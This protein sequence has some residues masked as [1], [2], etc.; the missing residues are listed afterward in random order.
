[1]I[2]AHGHDMHRLALDG[3]PPSSRCRQQPRSISQERSSKTRL[4]QWQMAP[5]HAPPV[6]HS[7]ATRARHVHAD[8]RTGAEPSTTPSAPPSGSTT[9]LRLR[10]AA[11]STRHA[12]PASR[13]ASCA[14]HLTLLKRHAGAAEETT[15]RAQGKVACTHVSIAARRE[16]GAGAGT[17]GTALGEREAAREDV[18]RSEGQRTRGRRRKERACVRE[19][20]VRGW[21]RVEKRHGARRRRCRAL[22]AAARR[23]RGVGG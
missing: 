23:R 3:P 17:R 5:H 22:A 14:S 20:A 7:R 9:P 4:P 16:C 1:M 2:G 12:A 8:W 13:P 11:V 21:E 10:L 18:E 19:C 15:R 6:A